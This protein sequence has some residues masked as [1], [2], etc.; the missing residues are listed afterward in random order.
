M[1]ISGFI[2]LFGGVI[3]AWLGT[4]YGNIRPVSLGIILNAVF[5][6]GL[7]ISNSPF[8]FGALYLL[9]N[10]AYYFMLP[11]MMGILAEMDDRGRWA[12]AVD[13]LWWLGAA[14]RSCRCWPGVPS[15]WLFWPLCSS[16]DCRPCLYRR[17]Y[18]GASQVLRK[19]G[20]IRQEWVY[21]K[22]TALNS[23]YQHEYPQASP[24]SEPGPC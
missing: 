21:A 8:L 24:I 19:S 2:G 14:P 15:R 18:P 17:A 13:A 10:A 4:R 5:A 12:V 7:A 11:Y 22:L 9:W 16:S 1:G 6:A 3:A 23:Q 20:K